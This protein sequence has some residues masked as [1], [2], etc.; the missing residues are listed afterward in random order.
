MRKQGSCF[1]GAARYEID[2]APMFVHCCHCTDCQTQTGS[3]FAINALI[4]ASAVK[5]TQGAPVVVTMKTEQRPPARHLPLRAMPDGAVERL[6]PPRLS[7][8]PARLNV[9]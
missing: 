3:A 6:R 7:L 1:C 4:E 8:L 9:R 2:R 5:L